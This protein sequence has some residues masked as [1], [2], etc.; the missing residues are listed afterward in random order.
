MLIQ[1]LKKKYSV[2]WTPE[3]ESKYRS[4]ERKLVDI[5]N[6]LTEMQKK[7]DE[8]AANIEEAEE[9]A[10]IK[11]NGCV[12]PGINLRIGKVYRKINEELSGVIFR[13]KGKEI[14]NYQI[15]S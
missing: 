4:I 2:G 15:I 14:I 10:Y 7:T 12:Y 6:K 13:M 9:K 8:L 11:V 3:Q 1:L 5:P